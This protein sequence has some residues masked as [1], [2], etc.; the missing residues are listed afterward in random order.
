EHHLLE[1]LWTYQSI[2]VVEPKL[3]GQLLHARDHRVRAAAV[4]VTNQWR[5][6]LKQ[7][8]ELIAERVADEHPQVRLEAVRALVHFPSPR[9]AEIA[10]QALDRP[11][12]KFLD[13][14]LWLTARELGPHWLPE[15]QAG[16]L[17]FGGNVQRLIFALQAVNSPAA[18]KPLVDLIQEGKIPAEREESALGLIAMLGGPRELRIVFDMVTHDKTPVARRSNLLTALE[19]AARQRRVKPEGELDEI[20]RFLDVENDLV[21]A[22]AARLAGLW[23][24]ENSRHHLRCLAI[25]PKTSDRLRP[26]AL[27]GLVLLG[28]DQSR[29]TLVGVA[30]QS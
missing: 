20:S 2:N 17:D 13:Y 27:E 1:A 12:D 29:Q 30:G 15:F 4:R 11:V 18:V 25:S 8:M 28:G 22:P 3:L 14:A 10:M 26:A 19:Q 16:K 9:A 5:T 6:R 21:A 24:N 7:P 23:R